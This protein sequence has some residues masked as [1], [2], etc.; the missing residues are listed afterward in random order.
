MMHAICIVIERNLSWTLD[1]PAVQN[2][3]P[4]GS[5]GLRIDPT[6]QIT[7]NINQK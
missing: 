7:N 1:T 2:K 3:Y 6:Y 4:D 5:N